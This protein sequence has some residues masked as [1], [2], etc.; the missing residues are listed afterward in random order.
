MDDKEIIKSILEGNKNDF[1]K[2]LIKYDKKVYGF[3]CKLVG[4][5]HIAQDL[6][7]ETF[8][9]VYRNLSSFDYDKNFI[10]W[11]F[12]I[13]K[14]TSFNYLKSN[15]AKSFEKIDE[16][17][18]HGLTP[19]VV[20]ENKENMKELYELIHNLPEKYRVLILLKYVEKL[21][22]EEIGKVLKLPKGKVESRLYIARQKLMS[23]RNKNNEKKVKNLCMIKN[24]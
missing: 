2:I 16:E 1:E 22:A 20:I 19:E 11:I 14:N 3:I 4:D 6:T 15:E 24:N 23:M 9:K 13:A 12:T 5:K 21:T 18:T 10:T 8:L 7:Q 17:F